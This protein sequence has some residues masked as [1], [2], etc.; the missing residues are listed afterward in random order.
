MLGAFLG[1]FYDDKPPPRLIVVS[2]ALEEQQLL[3]QALSIKSGHKVEILEPHRGEKRD[4]VDHALANAREALGRKLA[5]TSSQ[6]KLLA[7][8]AECFGLPGPPRRIEVYDNSHIQGANAVG[9]MIVAGADGFRKNQYRKF[10]MRASDLAPGDDYGMMRETL[11]RR[12]KRLMAEAPRP[13]AAAAAPARAR[14]AHRR[15]PSRATTQ[16][17]PMP[18]RTRPGPI[19]C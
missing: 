6:R 11:G 5:D 3:A 14:R 10:N 18:K 8:L 17:Q 9:A 1:Q 12:F 2:H 7:A 4:L 19:W 15:K 13:A 16:P